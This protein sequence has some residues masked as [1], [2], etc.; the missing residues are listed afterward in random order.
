MQQSRKP[1]ATFVED[2]ELRTWC[3]PHTDSERRISEDEIAGSRRCP[4]GLIHVADLDG[5]RLLLVGHQIIATCRRLRIPLAEPELHD[6]IR[7]R[8]EAKDWIVRWQLGGNHAHH[9]TP[10]ERAYLI[11]RRYNDEK[12]T[13][14]GARRGPS[15]KSSHLNANAAREDQQKPPAPQTT[16]QRLA[17][18]F[19]IS[20][21]TVRNYA[22]YAKAVERATTVTK[23]R[24]GTILRETP[25]GMSD[26]I[27]ATRDPRDAVARK[28]V[29]RLLD[30]RRSEQTRFDR[31]A[32]RR[33]AANRCTPILL[34]RSYDPDTGWYLDVEAPTDRTRW[35]DIYVFEDPKHPERA[36]RLLC[37]DATDP[38]WVARLL[39]GA[40]PKL[41]LADPPYGVGVDLAVRRQLRGGRSR[42][43]HKN[44]ELSGDTRAD[45]SEAFALVPSIETAYVWHASSRAEEVLH[46]LSRIGF[47]VRAPIYW[48]K[49][50]PVPS[51]QKHAYWL[52][53]ES[54]A[55]CV[56]SGHSPPWFGR[57][58]QANV[59]QAPTPSVHQNGPNA[60]V[61]HPTQKPV[62][63]FT[64]PIENHLR[65]GEAFYDPFCGSGSSL[66]AAELTGRQCYA[67]EYAPGLCDVIVDRWQ[68]FTGRTA[69][70]LPFYRTR[71]AWNGSL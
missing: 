61:D 21:A 60:R 14:G 57:P 19:A 32:S 34:N 9:L 70:K 12:A 2:D 4:E 24:H 13:H 35:G 38:G 1:S 54:C 46:G 20:A 29:L 22:A 30:R 65:V 56:Q 11:G 53:T 58:G 6:E 50:R 63:L 51:P 40:A 31:R 17:A 69:T 68:Q 33:R 42:S 45:W 43:S 8:S 64:T 36:H 66:I 37:G 18:I 49:A 62:E 26:L 23:R 44:T 27:D 59:W 47:T 3:V 28:R 5:R 39:A 48:L 7:T 16:A 25:Q 10:H 52:Q 67:M 71:K 41:M 15:A 55:F